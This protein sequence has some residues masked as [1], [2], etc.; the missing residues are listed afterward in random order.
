[1]HEELIFVISSIT[2]NYMI[3]NVIDEEVQGLQ[4]KATA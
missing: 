3:T 1:M 4:W 2:L